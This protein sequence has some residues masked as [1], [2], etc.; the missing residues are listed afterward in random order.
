MEV[1]AT[2]FQQLMDGLT[3]KATHLVQ[4][5]AEI[6]FIYDQICVGEDPR[7]FDEEIL[8]VVLLERLELWKFIV[9]EDDI[10]TWL[11]LRAECG[12]CPFGDVPYHIKD[13]FPCC[14][15]CKR[16]SLKMYT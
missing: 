4:D 10:R 5:G 7:F 2:T 3:H 9:T 13:P 6:E 16:K 8:I 14:P 11:A 12:T 15:I 1:P